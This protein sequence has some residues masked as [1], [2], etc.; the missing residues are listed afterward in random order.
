MTKRNCLALLAAC[1][2]LAGCLSA[3]G[4]RGPPTRSR[5]DLAS[6]G[7]HGESLRAVQATAGATLWLEDTPP[8]KPRRWWLSWRFAGGLP[9]PWPIA[10][11]E[12]PGTKTHP[13]PRTEPTLRRSPFTER[14]RS[15]EAA[16]WVRGRTP[17]RGLIAILAPAEGLR[18]CLGPVLWWG[19]TEQEAQAKCDAFTTAGAGRPE[20][21]PSRP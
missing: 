19:M 12:E 7:P 8:G 13:L 18:R 3:P 20:A 16:R 15:F 6:K 2:L 4:R 9:Q 14:P 1:G 10:V 11:F 17:A 21:P 5:L